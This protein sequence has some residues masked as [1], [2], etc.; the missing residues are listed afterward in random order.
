MRV[1]QLVITIALLSYQE[2]SGVA[3]LSSPL[4]GAE[5]RAKSGKTTK[6]SEGGTKAPTGG[7]TKAP[8]G[9]ATKAPTGGATVILVNLIY[10][11]FFKAPTGGATKAP[12]GGA[13]KAPVRHPM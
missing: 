2:S 9:G 5:R 1:I 4:R 12:T 3:A 11:T 13:T 10:F 7:A 6:K 8:T